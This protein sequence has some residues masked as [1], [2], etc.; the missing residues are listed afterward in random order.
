MVSYW[1]DE[2]TLA[3]Y[4]NNNGAL[5]SAEVL[6]VQGVVPV[7]LI[8]L[9]INQRHFVASC[10]YKT[11]RKEHTLQFK[12]LLACKRTS[13][14]LFRMICFLVRRK[15]MYWLIVLDMQTQP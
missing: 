5:H 15:S 12:S 10:A 6:G 11:K 4:F 8:Q 2:N 1:L 14:A 9:R 3:V 7:I 13:W